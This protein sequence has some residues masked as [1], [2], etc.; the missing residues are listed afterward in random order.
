MIRSWLDETHPNMPV[1][2]R[3][4][5]AKAMDIS[6]IEAKKEENMKT[7]YEINSVI[8]MSFIEAQFIKKVSFQPMPIVSFL[9]LKDYYFSPNC[10]FLGNDERSVGF[11]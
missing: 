8:R 1:E 9:F 7:I 10:L 5:R 2:D 4:R 6:L 11:G 3:E